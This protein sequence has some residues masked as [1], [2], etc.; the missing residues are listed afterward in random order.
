ME[1]HSYLIMVIRNGSDLGWITTGM[2][3]NLSLAP[4]EVIGTKYKLLSLLVAIH[5]FIVDCRQCQRR[6]NGDLDKFNIRVDKIR[7]RR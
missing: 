5:P 3:T 2:F 6:C 4:Q 7:L 1:A